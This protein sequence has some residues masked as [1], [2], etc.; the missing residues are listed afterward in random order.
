MATVAGSGLRI[1]AWEDYAYSTR[2]EHFGW[3]C[4]STLKL[5]QDRFAGPPMILEPTW[6]APVMYEA[7]AASEDGAPYWKTV[8]IV[9]TRKCAKT[10]TLGAFADYELEQG[11]G[12]PEILLAAGSDKQAGRLFDACAGFVRRSAELRGSLIVRHHVG[13]IART[14]GGGKIIR[15][16][17]EGDTQH[18]ATRR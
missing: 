2:G 16:S 5:G 1:A 6:Q 15:L 18:G 3:W 7:L 4:E 11:I 17:S 12:E 14:D 9:L 10:T 8:V 13:E